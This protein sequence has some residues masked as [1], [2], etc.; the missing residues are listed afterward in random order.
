[1]HVCPC[2]HDIF[3]SGPDTFKG[4]AADVFSIFQL[5]VMWLIRGVDNFL[6]LGGLTHKLLIIHEHLCII[7]ADTVMVMATSSIL[8]W[9]IIWYNCLLRILCVIFANC[10]LIKLWYITVICKI[11]GGGLKPPCPP[12]CLY[13]WTSCNTSLAAG[14]YRN[15]FMEVTWLVPENKTNAGM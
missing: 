14:K 4:S 15:I 7:S 2:I 8:H 6:E 3:R 13:P 12:L 5:K 9:V 1:M 11:W 10:W